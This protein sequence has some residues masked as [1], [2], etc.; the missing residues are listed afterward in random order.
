VAHVTELSNSK[1]K[2]YSKRVSRWVR[3][4]LP[5]YKKERSPSVPFRQAEEGGL[6]LI[7]FPPLLIG[8]SDLATYVWSFQAPLVM[9]I[10]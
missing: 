4:E 7:T 8:N 3:C 10:R 6:S 1:D 9:S 2:V 5:C